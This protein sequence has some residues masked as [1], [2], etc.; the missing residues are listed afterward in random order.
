VVQFERHIPP[1]AKAAIDL[2]A[3]T[4]RLKSLLKKSIRSESGALSG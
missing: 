1:E 3:V 4:A 2:A